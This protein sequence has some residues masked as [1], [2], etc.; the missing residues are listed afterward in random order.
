MMDQL[1]RS[2]DE[3]L[4]RFKEERNILH[5]MKGREADWIV[6]ILRGNCLLVHVTE[7]KIERTMVR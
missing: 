4:H 7:R 2:C 1:Y 5:A 6:Y 3:V